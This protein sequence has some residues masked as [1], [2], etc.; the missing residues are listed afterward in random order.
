MSGCSSTAPAMR[1]RPR[2]AQEEATGRA[3][4]H[5]LTGRPEGARRPKPELLGGRVEATGSVGRQ[6]A[7][8]PWRARRRDLS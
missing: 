1:A 3:G 6:A 7:P 5:D 4:P 8:L 2:T